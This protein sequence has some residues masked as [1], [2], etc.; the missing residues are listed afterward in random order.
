[1][2]RTSS[3]SSESSTSSCDGRK[4]LTVVRVTDVDR[5]AA[6]VL[7]GGANAGLALR[8]SDEVVQER[9]ILLRAVESQRENV[10]RVRQ[11]AIVK[12]AAR[13]WQ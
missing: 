6:A 10:A 2:T 7:D 11:A 9:R 12:I 13:E 1:M 5:A 8:S 4:P 3:S